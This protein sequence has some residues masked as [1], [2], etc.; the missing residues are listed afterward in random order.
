M[1]NNLYGKCKHNVKFFED[2]KTEVV[3]GILNYEWQIDSRCPMCGECM[4]GEEIRVALLN[5]FTSEVAEMIFSA[6]THRKE[7]LQVC[8]KLSKLGIENNI[9]PRVDN[10][11]IKE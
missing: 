7:Y 5:V 10:D 8:N 4:N 9:I 11:H 2:R 6:Y 3:G 1:Y